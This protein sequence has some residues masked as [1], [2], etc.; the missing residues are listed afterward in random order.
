MK[1]TKPIYR[2]QSDINHRRSIRLKEYDYS[3]NNAYFVTICA[4]NKQCLFGD[5]VNSKM[6]LNP[7]GLMTVIWF[8]ELQ[9]KYNNLQC[10]EFVCMPNHLHFII[11]LEG[12]G[13]PAHLHEPNQINIPTVIQWYKTMT[14]N[15]YIRGVKQ[16]DWQ[17]FSGKLWQRN[18]WERVIRNQDE[19]NSIRDYIKTNPM[20]WEQDKLFATQSNQTRADEY[21]VG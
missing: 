15:T 3:Q 4:Q 16:G 19:L 20:R 12:A 2:H 10:D 14:T 8:R 13:L 18:Y 7:A 1:T 17:P 6:V 9:K 11:K 21:P 5:I